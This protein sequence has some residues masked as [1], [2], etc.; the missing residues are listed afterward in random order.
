MEP[1]I[2]SDGSVICFSRGRRKK[3]STAPVLGEE[4]SS[5]RWPLSIRPSHCEVGDIVVA[6]KPGTD[7]LVV[8]RVAAVDEEGVFL[9]GDNEAHS[10]DSRS[11]G[12]VPPTAIVGTVRAV[13]Y[14]TPILGIT[15]MDCNS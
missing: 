2:G 14:F 15:F 10:I 1:T 13:I 6:R 11:Y 8:K 3:G 12:P 7:A 9:L 4:V 5:S